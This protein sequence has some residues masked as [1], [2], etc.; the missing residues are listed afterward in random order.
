MKIAFAPSCEQIKKKRKT[1]CQNDVYYL[2]TTVIVILLVL[3]P[4]VINQVQCDIY[5]FIKK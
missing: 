3:T 4:S 1:M 2:D 5:H